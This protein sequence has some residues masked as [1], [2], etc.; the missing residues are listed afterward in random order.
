MPAQLWNYVVLMT[1]MV[2][3]TSGM[4]MPSLAQAKDQMT[5]FELDRIIEL[6]LERN[7]AI[8]S[9]QS[10]IEQNEGLR[11]PSRGLSQPH[12]RRPDGEWRDSRP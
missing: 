8:A 5:T 7:P 11:D 9:A 12:G 2:M 10:V 6:A 4:L 3:G 1:V